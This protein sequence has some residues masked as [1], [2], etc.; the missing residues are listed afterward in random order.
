MNVAKDDKP[1]EDREGIVE[2]RLEAVED[3]VALLANQMDRIEL[4]LQSMQTKQ[5]M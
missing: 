1:E 4:L 5:I 3:R 2:K